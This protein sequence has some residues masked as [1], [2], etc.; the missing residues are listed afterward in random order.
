MWIIRIGR[1]IDMRKWCLFTILRWWRR[2]TSGNV[3]PVTEY[4]SISSDS[5]NNSS[6]SF[7]TIDSLPLKRYAPLAVFGT[8]QSHSTSFWYHHKRKSNTGMN[9]SNIT[10]QRRVIN[11]NFHPSRTG[12][13]RTI[14]QPLSQEMWE[15]LF[16]LSKTEARAGTKPSFVR[17]SVARGESCRLRRVFVR[18]A[19][20]GV[21]SPPNP[22]GSG[23]S[24]CLRGFWAATR[25]QEWI[26][27]LWPNRRGSHT[28][29]I[30]EKWR[31][32]SASE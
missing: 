21:L 10:T 27:D 2:S 19:T 18:R 5:M 7:M 20:Q 13:E 28:G 29:V 16:E 6:D 11:R 1:K 26:P 4:I 14:Q 9:V 24:S 25:C 15:D 23:P 17:K 3:G 30:S 8:R 12:L 32:I 22:H 31:M